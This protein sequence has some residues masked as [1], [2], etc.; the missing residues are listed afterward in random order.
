LTIIGGSGVGKSRLSYEVWNI[1]KDYVQNHEALCI[2]WLNDDKEI[3]SEFKERIL[4]SNLIEVFAKEANRDSIMDFDTVE[5]HLGCSLATCLFKKD[6]KKREN[7]S[8]GDI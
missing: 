4:G 1:L 7:V 3:F 2:K 8:I 5:F 6:Q